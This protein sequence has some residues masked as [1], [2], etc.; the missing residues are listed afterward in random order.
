MRGKTGRVPCRPPSMMMEGRSSTLF[1]GWTIIRSLQVHDQPDS[2]VCLRG[3]I[4]GLMT[5]GSQHLTG[6]SPL[7]AGCRYTTLL[8]A[9]GSIMVST[10]TA[11]LLARFEELAHSRCTKK[12]TADP[13]C[14]QAT[15]GWLKM[16]HVRVIDRRPR[17]LL[18]SLDE[19]GVG[20][21]GYASDHLIIVLPGFEEPWDGHKRHDVK[22]RTCCSPLLFA[23]LSGAER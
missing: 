18:V 3:I 6:L 12:H 17:N 8:V 22:S 21:P 13:L 19:Y 1:S 16:A 5:A 23:I 20:G 15:S 7:S 4:C 2:V 9:Q 10:A 11:Q 14:H